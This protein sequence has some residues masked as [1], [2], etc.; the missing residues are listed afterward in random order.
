MIALSTALP[1]ETTIALVLV[2]AGPVL[3]ALLYLV[4]R[5]RGDGEISVVGR[6]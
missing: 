6:R 4:D 5:S 3:A 2:A 1:L